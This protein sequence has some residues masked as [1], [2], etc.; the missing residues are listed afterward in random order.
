MSW[1][2]EKVISLLTIGMIAVRVIIVRTIVIGSTVVV[3]IGVVQDAF[4]SHRTVVLRMFGR[5]KMMEEEKSHFIYSGTH[6][7]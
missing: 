1:C 5:L 7:N 2:G 6:G 4:S 3:T